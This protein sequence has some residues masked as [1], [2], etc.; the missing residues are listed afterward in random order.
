[1]EPA[2][3]VK[4]KWGPIFWALGMSRGG[5][6]YYL[7]VPIISII[8]YCPYYSIGNND[9]W[10]AEHAK[11]AALTVVTNNEREFKRVAGLRVQNWVG[12]QGF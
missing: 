11:A 3:Y 6:K 9:L 1:M 8:Y 4:K 5:K 10:I 7:P 12:R 2:L